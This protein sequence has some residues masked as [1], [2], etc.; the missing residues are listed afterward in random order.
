MGYGFG[1]NGNTN[2]EQRRSN[3]NNNKY[4]NGINPSVYKQLVNR[5]KIFGYTL[6][7][8]MQLRAQTIQNFGMEPEVYVLAKQLADQYGF[9]IRLFVPYIQR[10][11]NNLRFILKDL[12]SKGVLA[13]AVPGTGQAIEPVNT[14]GIEEVSGIEEIASE[15]INQ[16]NQPSQNTGSIQQID[17]PKNILDP[18]GNKECDPSTMP[19][20]P[21]GDPANNPNTYNQEPLQKI[22]DGLNPP[23]K[24]K[25]KQPK[26]YPKEVIQL[27]Q[28]YQIH[29]ETMMMLQKNAKHFKGVSLD[30][31]IQIA[32]AANK[33]GISVLQY[34]TIYMKNNKKQGSAINK[35][36]EGQAA[37]TDTI[38]ADLM[39]QARQLQQQQ[40]QTQPKQSNT[41]GVGRKVAYGQSKLDAG[42]VEEGGF[43]GSTNIDQEYQQTAYG[44]GIESKREKTQTVFGTD[45]DVKSGKGR[46]SFGNEVSGTQSR[47]QAKF[48]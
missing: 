43:I 12:Q 6:E 36:I 8:F 9:D 7:Q 3:S 15:P 44:N 20:A 16:T 5:A 38:I 29:P 48:N 4:T 18:M 30:E 28:K 47:N 21:A 42:S 10:G 19:I 35:N 32:I 23:K 37:E 24:Q 41:S 46:P 11:I 25:K 40:Q 1:N 14:G 2:F 22:G 17:I 33:E 31:Y 45:K 34:Y 27:S 39:N 13:N 26:K